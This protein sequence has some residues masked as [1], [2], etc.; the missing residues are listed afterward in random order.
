MV[1]PEGD[2]SHSSKLFDMRMLVVMGGQER[3]EAEYETLLGKAGFRLTGVTPTQSAVSVLE[4][5][6]A[7]DTRKNKCYGSGGRGL[8]V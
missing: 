3:T 5:A 4:A 8:I 6:P 7:K 1:I 2:G